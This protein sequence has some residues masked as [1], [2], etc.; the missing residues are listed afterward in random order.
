VVFQVADTQHR[1]I[2]GAVQ[3]VTFIVPDLAPGHGH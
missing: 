1:P 3:T 2:A